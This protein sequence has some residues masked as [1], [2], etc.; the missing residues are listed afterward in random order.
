GQPG[1]ADSSPA[2]PGA[3]SSSRSQTALLGPDGRQAETG[4]FAGPLSGSFIR[5]HPWTS[6]LAALAAGA[7]LTVALRVDPD[8]GATDGS[9]GGSQESSSP[10]YLGPEGDSVA[11]EAV[12]TAPEGSRLDVSLFPFLPETVDF[13][14]HV[15]KVGPYR[16]RI[17]R[18]GEEARIDESPFEA[19]FDVYEPRWSCPP[20]ER[21]QLPQLIQLEIRRG[22]DVPGSS[23]LWTTFF[24]TR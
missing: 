17:T 14:E 11:R 20:A 9:T 15:P 4:P 12:H 13:G 24:R 1:F 23:A 19:T 5:E 6:S 3:A 8:S 7:L 2:V 21:S 16:V 18:L 10:T 22:M